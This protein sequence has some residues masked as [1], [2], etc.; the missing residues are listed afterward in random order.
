MGHSYSVNPTQHFNAGLSV[1]R[2]SGPGRPKGRAAAGLFLQ[3]S[4]RSRRKSRVPASCR[5]SYFQDFGSGLCIYLEL[6][7]CRNHAGIVLAQLM[8]A[9]FTAVQI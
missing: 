6:V 2:P 1:F 8:R 9:E 3:T 5:Q 4:T 7:T